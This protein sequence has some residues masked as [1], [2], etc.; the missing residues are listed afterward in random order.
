MS[1]PYGDCN[2]LCM[3][4]LASPVSGMPCTNATALPCWL[5]H[6]QWL[7][8]T[9]ASSTTRWKFVAGHHP[10]DAENMKHLAPSLAAY[11][12]QAYLA[13]HVH[14]MQHFF[15]EGATVNYFISGAGA[16][17]SA[18]AQR[19]AQLPA[20]AAQGGR[21]HLPRPIAHP[22][23]GKWAAGGGWVGDGPGF[24][25][26]SLDGVTATAKFVLHNG[27]VVYSSTFS[28]ATNFTKAAP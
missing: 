14:N 4:Q 24:L 2:E 8:S 11:G 3:L 19:A 12:A 27:S 26:L 10:I 13:G 25:S 1:A 16:F 6:L 28:A 9:L 15:E 20:A 18:V 5:S 21:T 17:A 22:F 7:N 23:G